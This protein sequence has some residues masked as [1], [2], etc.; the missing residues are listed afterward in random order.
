MGAVDDGGPVASPFEAGGGGEGDGGGFFV[1]RAVAQVLAF[2]E[3][4]DVPGDAEVVVAG[5][6]AGVRDLVSG[7]RAAL[8]EEEVL[9]GVGAIWLARTSAAVAAASVSYLSRVVTRLGARDIDPLAQVIDLLARVT[10]LRSSGNDSTPEGNHSSAAGNHSRPSGNETTRERPASRNR[11][12]TTA[13]VLVTKPW[14][15]D[16]DPG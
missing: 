4:A 14:S 10:D 13:L 3:D 15:E 1:L 9:L 6:A 5:S 16:T 7:A 8:V 12:V 2:D 11:A